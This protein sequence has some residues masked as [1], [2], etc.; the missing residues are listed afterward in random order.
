MSFVRRLWNRWKAGK[1]VGHRN[2]VRCD[3]CR[4]WHHRL[5]HAREGR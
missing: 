1:V 2:V 4:G 5:Y 3:Y